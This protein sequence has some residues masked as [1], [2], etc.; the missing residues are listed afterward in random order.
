MENVKYEEYQG[1][2]EGL[3]FVLHTNIRRSLYANDGNQ[4]WH[5]NIELQLCTE[6]QGSLLLDGA[7]YELQKNDMAIVTPNVLHYTWSDSSMVY[8]CLI[9][10][11]DFCRQMGIDPHTLS[12]PPIVRDKALTDLFLQLLKLY[13]SQDS[14]RIARLNRL[15]L[16]LLIET[17]GRY[18]TQKEQTA[19]RIS[20]V[21]Q[22]AVKRAI[23]FLR[24]HYAAE[25][26]LDEIAAYARLDKYALCRSFK[27]FTGQTVFAY[28]HHYRC[29]RHIDTNL[30][31]RC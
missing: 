15:L 10:S 11:T 5:E 30:N 3:P 24:E 21:R 18:A 16:E 12:F 7:V 20:D 28:L 13:A 19:L 9:L 8:A 14:L 29:I 31:Y 26:T 22:D 17:V 2:T 27:R 25:I 4:N 6:G 23:L 1:I